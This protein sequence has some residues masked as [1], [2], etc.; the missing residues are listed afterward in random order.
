MQRPSHTQ[1]VWLLV[2]LFFISAGHGLFF[3]DDHG[4]AHEAEDCALCILAWTL[5]IVLPVILAMAVP[6][7]QHVSGHGSR[8]FTIRSLSRIRG[9]RAP[10]K[11]ILP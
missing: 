5:A 2:A 4:H 10:P 7:P 8:G 11:Y 6:Q 9:Q 1:M 3:H